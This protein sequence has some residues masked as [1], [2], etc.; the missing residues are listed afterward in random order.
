MYRIQID[1]K[2]NL[3]ELELGGMLGEDEV[4][5]YIA[6]LKRRFA[7]NRMA[8]YRMILDVSE[9]PIQLQ[10][11]LQVMGKHMADMPRASAIA[12]VTGSS[13]SRMQVRRLFTQSYARIVSNTEDAR[14]WV[15]DAVEP[16]A[17]A[18]AVATGS[19]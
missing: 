4:A 19:A 1:K 8:N 10:N 3:V 12:V 15:L 17:E 5:E 13:L 7:L 6:E 18:P 9:C 16:P 14:A 2:N 11:T